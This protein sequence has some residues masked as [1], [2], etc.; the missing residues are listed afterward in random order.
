MTKV[1]VIIVI[2]ILIGTGLV[3]FIK[4]NPPAPQS[5]NLIRSEAETTPF[6]APKLGEDTQTNATPTP[7]GPTPDTSLLLATESSKAVIH[8]SRGNITVKLFNK[9]AKEAV[10]NF[11]V[12]AVRNFYDNLTFHRVEDW[13]I[14]GGDPEGN[15]TGGGTMPSVYNDKPFVTGSLGM[16]RGQDRSLTNDSQ[17]FITKSDASW[18][19]G[20][21]MNFGIVTDGM[22]VVNKIQ[23]GDRI[24][25]IEF[26]KDQ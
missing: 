21:Y 13:V 26:L 16:A 14:Q 19:N 4:Q 11:Y 22:D 10:E 8:T 7:A 15:G 23:I 25:D 24:L 6:Q 9:D 12:K 17:F 18:L 2:A 20:E 3:L 1:I 5:Q